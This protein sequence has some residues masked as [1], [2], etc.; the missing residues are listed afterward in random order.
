MNK[1]LKK[2]PG[3]KPAFRTVTLWLSP[4]L[5]DRIKIKAKKLNV[6]LDILIQQYISKGLQE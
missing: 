6:S 1:F 2:T 5:I 4:D 3:L